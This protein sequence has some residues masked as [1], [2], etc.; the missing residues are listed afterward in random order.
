MSEPI[1]SSAAAGAAGAAA[2]KAI[3]GPAAVAGCASALA[4]IVV[5]VMTLPRARGEW[6]VALIST[7]IASL[8]GG[9]AVIQYFG[10]A[11]WIGTVNGALALGGI[12]FACGLP[13]WALVRWLFNFINKRRDD[14]LAEVVD[15]VR[16]TLNKAHHG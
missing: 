14:D 9:A 3:G 16:E 7:V 8:S 10:M 6:A 15:D 1:S 2:F 13:G 11:H 12:Y 5:M 4:T